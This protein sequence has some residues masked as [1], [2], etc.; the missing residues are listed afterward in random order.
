[1]RRARSQKA[2]TYKTQGIAAARQHTLHFLSDAGNSQ[3]RPI[4][5]LLLRDAPQLK[6]DRRAA[7]LPR[8]LKHCERTPSRQFAWILQTRGLPHL[9]VLIGGVRCALE[10]ARR[11]AQL[12]ACPCRAGLRGGLPVGETRSLRSFLAK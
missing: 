7:V 2:W 1:M 9:V 3:E 6:K 11:R 4:L 12:G 10:E 5:L 8:I